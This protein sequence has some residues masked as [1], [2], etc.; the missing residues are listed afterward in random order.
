MSKNGA[1]DDFTSL[2]VPIH[3]QK[4]YSQWEPL[5]FLSEDILGEK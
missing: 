2:T 5:L 3:A 1:V 4:S